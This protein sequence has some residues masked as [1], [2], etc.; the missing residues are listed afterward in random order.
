MLSNMSPAESA[1]GDAT[2]LTIGK[3]SV[4]LGSGG[5]SSSGASSVF[6]SESL[7]SQ[8][9]IMMLLRPYITRVRGFVV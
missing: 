1:A 8:V 3:L 9:L 7:D 5:S 2:S 4:S 6:R